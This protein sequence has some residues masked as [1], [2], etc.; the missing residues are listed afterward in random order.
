MIDNERHETLRNEHY[1]MLRESGIR[2]EIINE[3]G[4]RSISTRAELKRLGYADSQ[5]NVPTLNIPIHSAAG[6]IALYHH[7]PNS[8]RVDAKGK[9][10]KY[11]FPK[12]SRM[13]VDVHP[14]LLH[15][16][17]NPKIPLFI[18]EGVKKADAAISIGLCC[19]GLI[20]TFNWRGTNEEGGRTALPDWEYVALKG[21]NNDPRQVYICF[22][23]DVM[24][25]KQ[26]YTALERLSAFLAQRGANIAFIYLPHGEDGS[27]T[28]LD[29]YLSA[30]HSKDD[31]L[32]LA[33]SEMRKPVFDTEEDSGIA[34]FQTIAEKVIGLAADVEFIH[35]ERGA[36]FGRFDVNGHIETHLVRSEAFKQ[37]IT[38]QYYRKYG[39]PATAQAVEDSLRLFESQARF[40][41]E[42]RT[43]SIRCARSNS[44][45]D[46]Y[47]DMGDSQWRAI[48]VTPNDWSIVDDTP[49]FRRY[50][51]Q[52]RFAEPDTGAK[53][54]D[55]E[56]LRPFV[57]V[58]SEA[59]WKQLI[60]W[61]VAAWIPE[62][63]HP[64]LV[65]HG[66]QGT[67]KSTLMKLLGA[68]VDPSVTPLRSE[69]KDEAQW[70]Q[71]ADHTW[72]LTIDNVS[73]LSNWLSDAICRAVTGDGS[74]KRQLYTDSEDVVMAFRRVIAITCI[75]VAARRSDLLDR[76]ILFG[77][78]P[79][80]PD[81]RQAE[82]K[83]LANF[84]K[85][86]SRLTGALLCILS[87]V[88]RV[89]PEVTDE[90]DGCCQLPRMADFAQIGIAAES[91]LGWPRGSFL[92]SYRDGIGE[93]NEEALASC[94]IY[95]PL[96]ST[97]G[98]SWEGTA[99]QLLSDLTAVVDEKVTRQSDWP[100]NA[101]SLSGT[102]RRLAPNLRAVG[103][104][105]AFGRG[106][107]RL[108]TIN[109]RDTSS[110]GRSNGSAENTRPGEGYEA[111]L[112]KL[113]AIDAN[114]G[115]SAALSL[116][117]ID[118]DIALEAIRR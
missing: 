4:Y 113:D 106:N 97:V 48:K 22:D 25:K 57:N 7:R 108:I 24:L 114:D 85:I 46:I 115:K 79:I 86:R 66:E 44:S 109:R 34:E 56:L 9:I 3:R 32:A 102:L 96:I 59:A 27:K 26:V 19:I 67:A 12:G 49:P 81:R 23:S 15:D 21:V 30:G 111:S 5:C 82:T 2:D 62:I 43:I 95:E 89:L 61:L 37:W 116:S 118:E 99:H 14:R 28:G 38:R 65:V 84:E 100:K 45:S 80:S 13:A 117:T 20:G 41:G 93:Q 103:T 64:V 105:V 69:P 87:G 74:V 91:V 17:R 75:E 58:R 51:T 110:S 39:K 11:E 8:P 92:A 16:I 52:A 60:V 98:L 101:R 76:S 63:G 88:L 70:T 77:L 107:R 1:N 18:T 73:V 6:G 10:V 90:A 104:D 72:L 83:V 68:L 31:L 55:I 29:D 78:E 50:A 35:S 112:I 42:Q 40:E 94:S 71:A 53:P 36:A 33:T 54:S 47:L